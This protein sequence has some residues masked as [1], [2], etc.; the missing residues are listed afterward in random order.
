[1]QISADGRPLTFPEALAY[2]N[3]V[4]GIAQNLKQEI[5]L[6]KISQA[7]ANISLPELGLGAFSV[8]KLIKSAAQMLSSYSDA[9]DALIDEKNKEVSIINRLLDDGVYQGDFI[10]GDNVVYVR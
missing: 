7:N 2:I 6:M 3:S 4:I 9:L 10:S 5:S 8:G 1:V